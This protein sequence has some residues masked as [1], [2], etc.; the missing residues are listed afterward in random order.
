MQFL[1]SLV[2]NFLFYLVI[3]IIFLLA[4]PTLILPNK[5]T[6]LCGK[7]LAYIII[8]LIRY[9]LGNKIVFSGLENLKKHEKFC[10]KCTSIFA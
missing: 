9:I 7:I 6:L 2:F 4:I 1:R 5:F 10:C 8:F 3:V